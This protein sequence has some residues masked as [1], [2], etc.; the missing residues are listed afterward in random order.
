[1][2]LFHGLQASDGVSRSRI[3]YTVSSFRRI[4]FFFI[5]HIG[6]ALRNYAYAA[7]TSAS[8]E[9]SVAYATLGDLAGEIDRSKYLYNITYSFRRLMERADLGSGYNIVAAIAK[10]E[11]RADLLRFPR[12]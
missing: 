6:S 8:A 12:R 1:M 11:I 7:R 10:V 3:D 5:V 4:L 9:A 2:Y